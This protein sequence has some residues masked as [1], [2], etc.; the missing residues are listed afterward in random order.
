M[1]R[2]RCAFAQ[3]LTVQPGSRE[4]WACIQDVSGAKR[5]KARRGSWLQHRPALIYRLLL[6]S[7]DPSLRL[8]GGACSFVCEKGYRL[9]LGEW[10]KITKY[11]YSNDVDKYSF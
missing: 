9:L 1:W 7:A 11:I 8:P 2:G 6:R 3:R 5:D 10:W 4:Q